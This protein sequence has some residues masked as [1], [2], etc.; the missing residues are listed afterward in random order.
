MSGGE[1]FGAVRELFERVVDLDP[2]SRRMALDDPTLHP[3]VREDVL[4]LLGHVDD[5][6]FLSKPP[7]LA[8]PGSHDR[9]L[10]ERIGGFRLLRRIG[11][12]GM[13]IV[14]EAEQDHPRR[15]VAIKLI[16]PDLLSDAA[17]ARFRR[18]AEL[19]GRLQHP[20]IAAVF[21]A[22]VAIHPH[23]PTI[24][25]PFAAME[26]VEGTALTAWITERQPPLD[27]RLDLLARI[28]DAVDHAHRRGVLHRDLK[29]ANILV[30]AEGDPKILDFGIARTMDDGRDG[31]QGG[32]K[33][34]RSL[35]TTLHTAHGD[36]IGTLG[37]MSPEQLRGEGSPDARSDVYALGVLAYEALSGTAPF[38]L[39]T[40]GLADAIR[41]LL[42][43]EPKPLRAVTPSLAGDP[44][45]IVAT[46]MAKD[47]SRR[48][49]TAAALAS[50]LRACRDHRPIQARP[51]GA[52]YVIRRFAQR[53]RAASVAAMLTAAAL[54]ASTAWSVVAYNGE[55]AARERA[56][57][58]NAT[59]IG[60]LEGLD[61]VRA[62]GSTL[63]LL[64][65]LDEAARACADL[66]PEPDIAVLMHQTLGER[67]ARLDAHER[68]I[69]HFEYSATIATDHYGASS[70]ELADI[71]SNLGTSYRRIGR[72]D[73]AIDAQRRA[74][75]LRRSLAPERVS[76]IA[77]SLNNLG[78]AEYERGNL[79][80]AIAHFREVESLARTSTDIGTLH[81]ATGLI[82]LG[83][84]HMRRGEMDE[85]IRA[86]DTTLELRTQHGGDDLALAEA[87][88]A[89]GS[90]LLHL[91]N[92]PK[93][94]EYL[95][96]AY[97]TRLRLLP[98]THDQLLSAR[99]GLAQG[100]VA[101]GALQEAE[102]LW[103]EQIAIV[104]RTGVAARSD[105]RVRTGDRLAE[106]YARKGDS[107]SAERVR[108]IR[109]GLESTVGELTP[110]ASKADD[111][112]DGLGHAVHRHPH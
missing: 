87:T 38:Q 6:A 80:R 104:A 112:T 84:V 4:K 93:A 90:A 74:L 61:P 46:A 37:C 9:L 28:C 103:L 45:I 86:F 97:E 62:G 1:R 105:G 15:S 21:A 22:G 30:T 5:E 53:H 52:M 19:L 75:D 26:L 25:L 73:E 76:D 35:A 12:G 101:I 94:V 34:T 63:D 96:F 99:D 77:E 31:S 2:P 8:L 111:D 83:M 29:P 98:A 78:T 32:S 85:A 59:L 27:E 14:Y 10:G 42:E 70:L 36:V 109:D 108:T 65:A 23:D 3:L 11:A 88:I 40:R 13:G 102:D 79:D 81:R 89:F 71:L 92:R 39:G 47:A 69:E 66:E 106:A 16:R 64:T 110:D 72:A 44:T 58:V 50:D 67:Y 33:P 48:Y 91:G 49:P 56:D 43:T 60:M 20:G 82:N 18:E 7:S 95:R 54:I 100:L 55:R 68:A 41:L 57:R 51:P 17:L 24:L 107:T